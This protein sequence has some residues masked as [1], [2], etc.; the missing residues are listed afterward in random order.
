ME[1]E[2]PNLII[3]FFA[4][5]F[6]FVSPCVLPLVPA[7]IGYMSGRASRN[8][9]LESG[10]KASS[11]SVSRFAMLLHGLA[12]VL[13]F[14]TV[15]VGLS[16]LTTVF[17]SVLGSTVS[18]F[19]TIIGRVGGLVIIFFGLHFMGV[20]R[21]I[22][23]K[24][25]ANADKISLVTSI[26]VAVIFGLII[27]WAFVDFVVSLP[28]LMG[29]LLLLFLGG[30]FSQPQ[31]FWIRV[32]NTIDNSLYRDT[33]PEME[34]RGASG[35][36]GS[37]SMG[38]VFAAG[39]TPCI[40]PLLGSILTVA[41]QSG[42]VP[43]AIVSLTAYSL[44]LGIPFLLTAGL[45]E[46]AQAVLRRLKKH[47]RKIELVS[48]TM[49]VLV[50]IS[51]AS[52]SLQALS[53][54]L[55]SQTELASRIEECG[56]GFIEGKLSFEEASSCLGGQLTPIA[57]GQS[58]TLSL[59][60]K[61]ASHSF[62]FRLAEATVVDVEL[63]GLQET[64]PA[65]LVLV[66]ENGQEIALSEQ[67]SQIDENKYLMMQA[68]PLSAGEYTASLRYAGTGETSAFRFR[69]RRTEAVQTNQINTITALAAVSDAPEGL[70][71]GR[72][73]PDFETTN[74]DGQSVNLLDLR[75]R[76]VLINFWGTW[77][78]PCIREMPDLQQVYEDYQ[79][80]GFVILALATEGDTRE[81]VLNFRAE[82]ELSFP[83]IVDTDDLI[84]DE[85]GVI[86]RPSTFILDQE[87]VIVFR[88]YGPVVA[89]QVSEILDG[90]LES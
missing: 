56:L 34:V 67:F 68:I 30:A 36:M 31:A 29:F 35:L 79:D 62:L 42:N 85:Y 17:I 9:A 55:S 20:I 83:L 14:T 12:F 40:G 45:M 2:Y 43:S 26:F 77:C 75:G 22:F 60:S 86:T 59:S 18:I 8:I 88:N 69:I 21:Q 27:V 49:L 84:N 4:G 41:A 52:G 72:R 38:I 32:L 51:V 76:V 1:L 10:M 80:R 81:E 28:V 6:S 71:I 50:G 24:I 15:F 82:H 78:A 53:Q 37:F 61:D 16:I 11:V 44:G 39:W 23:A 58:S 73:A 33:R 5:L 89:S 3:A 57:L 25:R 48:G 64:F 7:Y 46:G 54:S 47:M 90:L 13:G 65:E 63:A 87:G 70:D 66:D 19:T 74:I